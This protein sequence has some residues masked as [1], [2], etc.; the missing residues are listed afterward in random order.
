MSRLERQLMSEGER[1]VVLILICWLSERSTDPVLE[2]ILSDLEDY[3]SDLVL[4]RLVLAHSP[5]SPRRKRAL[6][7][8][9]TNVNISEQNYKCRRLD[10]GCSS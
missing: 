6:Q 8:D 7:L 1:R 9:A 10:F 3:H 4:R 2:A 5:L